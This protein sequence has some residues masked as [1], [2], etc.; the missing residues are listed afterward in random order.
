VANTE[1][2]KPDVEEDDEEEDP[3]IPQ[4]GPMS[5][6]AAAFY[7]KLAMKI[8]GNPTARS[9]ALDRDTVEEILEATKHLRVDPNGI[10]TMDIILSTR[11]KHEC[12]VYRIV[13]RILATGKVIIKIG[14]TRD[15][16]VRK[17]IYDA[18]DLVE[19]LEFQVLLNLDT[20]DGEAEQRLQIVYDTLMKKFQAPSALHPAQQFLFKLIRERQGERLG[21]KKPIVGQM[22]ES[23]LQKEYNLPSPQKFLMCDERA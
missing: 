2:A 13:I 5:E 21:L 6:V 15:S 1:E 17:S 19:V 18:S 20:M 14:Y 9:M 10:F 3:H 23:A 7:A 16:D 12:C 4:G 8:G 22:I 11:S